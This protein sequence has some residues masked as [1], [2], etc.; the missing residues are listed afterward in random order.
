MAAFQGSFK[1]ADLLASMIGLSVFK[2]TVFSHFS[3]YHNMFTQ[4]HRSKVFIHKKEE[5]L[6]VSHKLIRNYCLLDTST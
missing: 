3:V 6:F 5:G 1:L 2:W 4:Y